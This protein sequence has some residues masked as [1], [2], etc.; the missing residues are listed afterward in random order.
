M[1]DDGSD[2]SE[3]DGE[4]VLETYREVRVEAD[5]DGREYRPDEECRPSERLSTGEASGQLRRIGRLLD[6]GERRTQPE[7][8]PALCEQQAD[9]DPD[10]GWDRHAGNRDHAE[11]RCHQP[12]A[13]AQCRNQPERRE[14]V[15]RADPVG[16]GATW[17]R[18]DC[19]DDVP[20][21]SEEADDNSRGFEGSMY[22]GRNRLVSWKPRLNANIASE[23]TRTSR[24]NGK[25]CRKV[26][27]GPVSS[28][29]TA[30]C[31]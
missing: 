19:R 6:D 31:S 18:E 25:N 4:D 29:S 10:S 17:L 13:E 7:R 3:G 12:N 22:S 30:A 9:K 26:P 15:S 23:S 2:D 1:L 24:S 28:T 14:R 5:Q 21:S 20:D 16:D 27:S 8:L 11:G